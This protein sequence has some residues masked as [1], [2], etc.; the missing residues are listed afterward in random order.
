MIVFEPAGWIKD[1]KKKER[2]FIPVDKI[3]YFHSYFLENPNE[4]AHRDVIFIQM[5]GEQYF[6]IDYPSEKAR[7]EDL[8]KLI[9][10]TPPLRR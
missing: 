1:Q 2:Y 3:M 4:A 8:Y 6:L 5:E 9:N 7:D 10:L